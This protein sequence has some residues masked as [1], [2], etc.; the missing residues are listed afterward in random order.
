VLVSNGVY[1][2]TAE[3]AIT[4]AITLRSYADGFIDPAG[5][6]L[7]AQYPAYSN[8]LMYVNHDNA[9]VDGFTLTNGFPQ[10]TSRSGDGGA[11]YLQAGQVQHCR[12][13][14]NRSTRYGGGARLTGANSVMKDC[15]I[16]DNQSSDHGGGVFLDTSGFVTG[17]TLEDN[18]ANNG[19][20]SGGGIYLHQSGTI[21]NCLIRGNRARFGGGVYLRNESTSSGGGTLVDSDIIQNV[22]VCNVGGDGGA[23]IFQ[24]RKS[25]IAHCRVIS[26]T[27]D[28]IAGSG[29]GAGIVTGE[30]G[31]VRDSLIAYNTGATYGGGL[32][33]VGR[34]R[35]VKR[36]EIR[37][38]S[39]SHGGGAELGTGGLVADS[40]VVSN[41]SAFFVQG[42]MVRNSLIAYNQSGIR[43][44]NVHGGIY[45]NC[46]IVHN[47]NGLDIGF[48]SYAP[49][50]IVENCIIYF[51]GSS[52]IN[53]TIA[54][55]AGL[56]ATNSCLLPLPT[57]PNDVGNISLDP[58]IV[59]ATGGNFNLRGSSPC[60]NQGIYRDWMADAFD[61][62]G[63]KRVIG[64]AVDMG[65]F[66][67]LPLSTL[68]Q[69]R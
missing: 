18:V 35:I 14:G 29:Y 10:T 49:T 50:S 20:R 57:G 69:V 40:V 26:N 7:D 13:V 4:T 24:F 27:I 51:N 19:F 68:L 36:C 11:I 30:G 61:L 39:A 1:F 16:L 38:N 59:N 62:Q 31:V 37:N 54:A 66:E 60:I 9:I 25:L 53:F 32:S 33:N 56:V 63:N 23:G 15:V 5:T 45:Q 52:G 47:G 28:R 6:I 64:P 34:G 65:A 17:C 46:T 43:D 41:N 8:R 21:T 44:F 2:L 22:S 48:G 3:I 42:G 55:N 58:R 12:I 67:Y